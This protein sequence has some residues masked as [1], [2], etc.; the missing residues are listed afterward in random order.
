MASPTLTLNPVRVEGTDA[1]KR[2]LA[3]L[4]TD[5][6]PALAAALYQVGEGVMTDAKL[7]TPVD[8]GNLRASGHVSPPAVQGS[9]VSVTLGFGGPAGSG[10]HG[11][12]SNAESVGYAVY[13]HENMEAHHPVGQA[14]FL[15]SAL[16][17][18]TSGMAGRIGLSLQRWIR[19]HGVAG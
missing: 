7:L 15:E 6:L 13:V 3:A 9:K 14:K 8:T 19:S 1:I 2:A 11:G 10:N 16:K 17:A 12:Q 4:G 18:R 5:V